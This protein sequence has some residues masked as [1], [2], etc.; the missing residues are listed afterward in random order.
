M[1][2]FPESAW[3]RD[4]HKGWSQRKGGDRKVT[5]NMEKWSNSFCRPSFCGAPWIPPTSY[6]VPVS[7]KGWG[8]FCD[9]SSEMV[10][11]RRFSVSLESSGFFLVS[12]FWCFQCNRRCCLMRCL[13]VAQYK[14]WFSGRRWGQQLLSFQSPAVHWMAWT[15][16]LNCLSCRN[17]YQTLHSLKCLP[18]FHWKPIAFTEKCFFASPSQ[19]IR[20]YL[21][22]L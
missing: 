6:R 17:P 5:E 8:Q 12:S 9:L 1:C 11:Q 14:S 16:S 13:L 18:P 4:M 21:N 3:K 10:A 19:K 2:F 22:T 20:S 7:V 15:S